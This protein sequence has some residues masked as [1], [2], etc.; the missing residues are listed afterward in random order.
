MQQYWELKLQNRCTKGNF[1]WCT[2][3][4]CAPGKELPLLEILLKI[5]PID[6]ACDEILHVGAQMFLASAP[7]K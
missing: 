2:T 3:F 6:N 5:F 4:S 7:Q 1:A